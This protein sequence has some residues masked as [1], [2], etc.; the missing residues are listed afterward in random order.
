MKIFFIKKTKSKNTIVT[1]LFCFLFSS[2]L[3]AQQPVIDVNG[4]GTLN[5]LI[6][7]TTNSIKNNSKAFSTNQISIELQSI[8]SFDT[9]IPIN[10]NVEAEDIYKT[11]NISSGIANQFTSNL[12]Y[13]CHSLIQYYYWPDGHSDRMNN[14]T[15][16]NGT[17]WDYV[18]IG[19]D[20]FMIST[21]PGYYSLGVNKIAAKVH[22][23]GAIPL[24]LMVW[25]EDPSL[26]GHFEEFTYRTADG[27][28]VELKN[29]PAALAWN[30]LPSQLKDVASVQPTPNGSYL[31]AASIYSYLYNQSAS[32]SQY[33]YNDSIA[34]ITHS[35]LVNEVSQV[36]Y[37]GSR[38]FISPYKSC[39]IADQNLIYNHGGTSTE[40]GILNGLQWV[41]AKDQKTLQY[42]ATPPIHFNYGRSSMGGTHLYT[43]D[44]SLYDYSFGYPLQDDMSTG[45]VSMQ[46]G[47]DQRVNENDVETDLGVALDMVRESELPFARNVP[48]RTIIS[49]MLEEIPGI[50]IYPPGDSWHLS[51]DV[52]KAIASYMYTIL[53]SDCACEG[54]DEPSDSTEW[55]T[56]MANKIGY[57]TAWNVMY[58]EGHTP[59]YDSTLSI[60][61]KHDLEIDYV[62]YPNPTNGNFTI[63]LKENYKSITVIITNLI[64]KQIRSRTYN[65]SQLLNFTINEPAGIY[66]IT[67]DADHKRSSI[68]L[69][70]SN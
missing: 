12:D 45:L 59:C 37:S 63:D 69:V 7:G 36:H 42:A 57:T 61:E 27:A 35:T 48:L 38:T 47:I 6:I 31:A 3:Q 68:R 52:N 56:W 70:K 23:G 58:L 22:Q 15:G 43:I 14:L 55:R 51:A 21:I 44:P 39:D 29:I 20:P 67:I 53:T 5:I 34:D 9:S 25:P 41:V 28:E 33:V 62:V 46:Y 1:L 64:G 17:D 16:D 26:I 2:L 11:K 50:D 60:I 8:L 65:N 49:Q 13:F 40:N 18:I 19:A 54:D 32:A 10:V 30:D 4:D 66:I 24:L